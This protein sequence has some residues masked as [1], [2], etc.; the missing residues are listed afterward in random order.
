MPHCH[1][2]ANCCY[3]VPMLVVRPIRAVTGTYSSCLTNLVSRLMIT[4]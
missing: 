1:R 4:P 2:T 3:S